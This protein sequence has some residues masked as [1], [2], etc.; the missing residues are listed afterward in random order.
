MGPN[1]SDGSFTET[2]HGLENLPLALA[3]FQWGFFG[4]VPAASQS[5]N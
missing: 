5:V 1:F 2:L 4:H 3:E